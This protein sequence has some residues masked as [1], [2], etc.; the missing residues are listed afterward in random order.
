VLAFP[1]FNRSLAYDPSIGLGVLLGSSGGGRGGGTDGT[2]VGLIVGVVVSI[3]VAAIMVLAG[4]TAAVAFAVWKKRHQSAY[5]T[6]MV[7]F[8]Q[9]GEEL[10]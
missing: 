1:G 10:L 5:D 7:N 6:D 3:S 8:V 2:D 4:I 9:D